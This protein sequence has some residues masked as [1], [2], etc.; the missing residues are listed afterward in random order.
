MASIPIETTDRSASVGRVFSRAFGTIGDNAVV[1]FALA[2]VFGALPQLALQ[3]AGLGMD[4]I[5]IG[6]LA[7]GDELRTSAIIA[8]GTIAVVAV[9]AIWMLTQAVLVRPVTAHA[10]GRRASFGEA[11]GAGLVA[12]VWLVLL[13]LLFTLGVGFAFMF[14]VVPGILLF[15]IWSVAIP[16]CV[17]ERLGPIAALGR[18]RRLT[19]G[20]RWRVFAM[21]L[22]LFVLNIMAVSIFSV[23]GVLIAGGADQYVAAQGQMMPGTMSWPLVLANAVFQT[24]TSAI[25]GTMQASLY[26]EL[27]DWKDGPASNRLADIFG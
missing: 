11:T 26:V 24:L 21:W 14:V 23:V 4:N 18:S 16:A 13:G 6:E 2:F 12:I 15:V 17:A 3:I 7:A 22:V 8:G 5:S 25:W 10:E 27:R 1:V 9:L 19:K 20:A